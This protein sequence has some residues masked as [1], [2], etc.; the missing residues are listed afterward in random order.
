MTTEERGT[1]GGKKVTFKLNEETER[2]GAKEEVE[3]SIREIKLM[4]EERMAF[5]EN[6]REERKVVMESLKIKERFWEERIKGL[7]EKIR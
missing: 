7:E 2:R 3:D 1:D 4:R 5:G 6:I